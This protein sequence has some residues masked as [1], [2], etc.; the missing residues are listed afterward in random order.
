MVLNNAAF[1]GIGGH[2]SLAESEA[3]SNKN[4]LNNN[5]FGKNC[6]IYMAYIKIGPFFM[7]VQS[8]QGLYIPCLKPR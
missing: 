4:D 3:E 7:H 5:G 6:P 2:S 8:L 1:T